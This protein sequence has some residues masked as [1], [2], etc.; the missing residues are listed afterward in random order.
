MHALGTLFVS[1]LP[2]F[3]MH[4]LQDYKFSILSILI[5]ALNLF[6]SFNLDCEQVGWKGIAKIVRL[7]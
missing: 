1:L 6:S 7:T 4:V 2:E 3:R 5:R